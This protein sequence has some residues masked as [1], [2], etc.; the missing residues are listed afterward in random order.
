MTVDIDDKDREFLIKNLCDGILGDAHMLEDLK[1]CAHDGWTKK[2]EFRTNEI[3]ESARMI[4][5]LNKGKTPG[6]G[7]SD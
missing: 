5:K 6:E 1:N 4:K 7:G 3:I 2:L